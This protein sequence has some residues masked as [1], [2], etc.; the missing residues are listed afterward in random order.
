MKKNIVGIA[1][2]LLAGFIVFYKDLGFSYL[3]HDFEYLILA[4][5]IGY[6]AIKQFLKSHWTSSFILAVVT[7][8]IVN[9]IYHFLTIGIGTIILA[10]FI[11][12]C[13]LSLLFPPQRRFKSI[14]IQ[15]GDTDVATAFGKSVKYIN[16]PNFSYGKAEV[17]FGASIIYFDNAE[18]IDDSATFNVE[19]A[20]GH[21]KLYVPRTWH[22][23]I[24]ATNSLGAINTP[25]NVNETH[26]VLYISGE[27]AFGNLEISYL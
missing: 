5:F 13:G 7:F 12:G 6:L 25:R 11:A 16:N 22:V 9:N 4:V 8:A 14:N 15:E 1:L 26:K 20:F 27:V 17:A 18:I 19:V 3:S 10:T 23:E 21:M 2:L 24:N